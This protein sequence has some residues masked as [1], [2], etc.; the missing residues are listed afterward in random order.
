MHKK[1]LQEQR[2]SKQNGEAEVKGGG[3][4]G[5][6]DCTQSNMDVSFL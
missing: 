3:G 5:E 2:A 6:S 4:E 1:V